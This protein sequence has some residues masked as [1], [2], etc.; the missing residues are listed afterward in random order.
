MIIMTSTTT[1]DNTENH[2]HHSTSNAIVGWDHTQLHD[3]YKL[4]PSEIHDIQQIVYTVI[5]D[6]DSTT[7]AT[8]TWYYY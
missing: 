5:Q 3:Q 8:T 7:G 1:S 4:Q 2:H 6:V